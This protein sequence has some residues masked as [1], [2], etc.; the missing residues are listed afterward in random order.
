[1]WR[2]RCVAQDSECWVPAYVCSPEISVLQRVLDSAVS[3]DVEVGGGDIARMAAPSTTAPSVSSLSVSFFFFA[4]T[5]LKG[6]RLCALCCFVLLLL[7]VLFSYTF[8]HN[9]ILLSIYSSLCAVQLPT[10]GT[11]DAVTFPFGSL[12]TTDVLGSLRV[13]ALDSCLCMGRVRLAAWCRA[14]RAEA[15][16]DSSLSSK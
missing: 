8:I 4:Q 16:L 5:H 14:W 9:L 7:Q 10:G 12:E 3:S 11:R 2:A 1:M 6:I 13:C 15:T